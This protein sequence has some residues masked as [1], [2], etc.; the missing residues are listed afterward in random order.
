MQKVSQICKP[1]SRNSGGRFSITSH[2]YNHQKALITADFGR[3]L[4]GSKP[5]NSS[6]Y[7]GIAFSLSFL[8]L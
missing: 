1:D 3:V 4:L 7:F 2:M 5:L 6:I 8:L